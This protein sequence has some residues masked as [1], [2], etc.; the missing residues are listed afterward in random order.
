[1]YNFIWDVFKARTQLSWHV[2]Y[3]LV[4]GPILFVLFSLWNYWYAPYASPL[5][6]IRGPKTKHWFYGFLTPAEA[7]EL[8]MSPK[9]L[10]YCSQYDGVWHA[11]FTNRRPTLVLGDQEAINYVLNNAQTYIRAEAQMRVT[12]LVFGEGLVGVDGPQHKRQRKVVGPA[13]SSVAVD[14]MA[15][16]FFL[17]AEKLANNWKTRFSGRKVFE[18]NAYRDFEAL[19]MDI[20][21]LAG[22][23]YDFKSLQGQRSQLEA[24][25]VNVTKSA[26]TGSAYASLRAQF[27]L[28]GALGHFLSKE[29]IQLDRYKSDIEDIS[30]KL[31][32]GARSRIK[33]PSERLDE[34]GDHRSP[35]NRDILTLL[36]Q[37]NLSSDEKDRLPE[38]EIVSMVPTFLSGGYDNNAAVMSYA[39]YGLAHFPETQDRLRDEL[40]HPPKECSSWRDSLRALDRLPYLDAVTREVL[41]LYSSAHSI[42]RTCSKDDIIPLDK[43][44][45]LRDGT[46]TDQVRIAAGDDVVIPQKWMNIDPAKWGPDAHVFKPERWIESQWHP[47]FVGGLPP[48]VKNCKTSGWSNLMTFSLGPRNCIGYRMAVAEFKVGLAV[49]VSNFEFKKHDEMK[50]VYGEVQIVDRPRVRGREGYCM[51][52]WVKRL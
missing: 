30:K 44:I 12:R 28:I 47:H 19:S 27:P 5:A 35:R 50:H 9:L 14:G 46:W 26:A 41:R 32:Q 13:F 51:P 18:T 21:G 29:Q 1:M 4:T 8:Q 39:V 22:F 24:A 25:F 2:F 37:S 42:P 7:R 45:Q 15:P 49:L 52:V 16:V 40:L 20:I 36:V 31:V 10:E 38:E 48:G 11:T 43:P 34:A 3:L 6:C 17:M 23:K 33:Q